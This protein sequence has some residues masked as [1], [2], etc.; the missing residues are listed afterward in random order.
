MGRLVEEDHPRDEG[1]GRDGRALEGAVE[2]GRHLVARAGQVERDLVAL[3]LDGDLDRQ[4]DAA[5]DAVVVE[6]ADLGLVAP[7]RHLRDLRAQHALRVLEPRVGGAEH[8]LLPVAVEQL[9]VAALGQLAGGDHRLDVA[10]VEG[11]RADVVEDVLPEPGL[12]DA[13]LLHLDRAVD[14]PLRPVVDEVDGQAGIGAADVEH[15]RR[16]AG[17][18][19]QLALVEDR[20]HDRHVR[21]VRGAAVGVVVEDDVALVD[22]VAEDRDH[23]LD[24]LR[25]RAHEHRRRVRL[26]Q[27]VAL[28]VEDAGAEVLGLADDRRVGHAVED[29]G[30]LLGDGGEGA[31]DHAHEDRRREARGALGL[32]AYR[33]RAVDDDVPEAVD[34][35]GEAGRDDGRRVVLLD[36]RRALDA[37]A[38]A[39]PLALVERRDERLGLAAD[40]EHDLA[41]DRPARLTGRRRP[42]RARRAAAR[43][44]GRCR[45]R[46]C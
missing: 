27:L 2:A 39:Q 43:R 30:H 36:H 7:V 20:D 31:A 15:V 17:E 42:A 14:V 45:R 6:P 11:R 24:D 18:A 16:R 8:R 33:G 26:G 23:V 44:R 3:D 37:V 22:V 40:V 41:L 28:R 13:L 38:G 21:R 46:G 1:H 32:G 5:V 34:L 9:G 4:L 25:H 19:D 29:A 12:P 35:G 10:V